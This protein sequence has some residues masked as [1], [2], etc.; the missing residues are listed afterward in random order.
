MNNVVLLKIPRVCLLH[1]SG[2]PGSIKPE[3]GYRS[4]PFTDVAS[5][6]TAKNQKL[7]HDKVFCG[8]RSK[9]SSSKLALSGTPATQSDSRASLPKQ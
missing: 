2:W 1:Y 3:V 9:A 7:F 5:K 8:R 6:G 4:R